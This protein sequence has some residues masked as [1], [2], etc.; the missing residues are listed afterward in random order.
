[1]RIAIFHGNEVWVL[2]GLGMD[3]EK[4]LKK[5]GVSVSRHQV[6][7]TDPGDIP[8][9]DWFFFVQQGQMNTILKAWKY[10]KD[11]VQKSICIFT[12]F[13]FRNCN[14]SLLKHAKVI[15]HM[16]SHQMAIS[17]ANGLSRENSY[18]MPLGVDME[19]HFPLKQAYVTDYLNQHYPS[20]DCTRKK[21]YI[22]FCTRFS[23]K[24]TYT[25]RKNYDS[26][27]KIINTLAEQNKKVLIVGDGW[28]KAKIYKNKENLVVL[29]PPYKDFNVFYSLMKVF[30]SVTTYEGGPIPVLESMACGIPPVISNSGFAMDI[31]QSK[32]LGLIFPPFESEEKILKLINQCENT[33]FDTKLL[34]KTA[35]KFSFDAYAK[36]LVDILSRS[37]NSK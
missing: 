6:N 4:A 27:L 20:I 9:A 34:R 5:L 36:K 30:V 15:S 2:R 7:L 26:M 23:G 8:E 10:R 3:I 17:I 24:Q 31:I 28:E 12:H 21:T 11:L 25:T 29:N 16:S 19:R 37:S 18:L 14:F 1:M 35:S 13:N 22:G 32:D 33:N